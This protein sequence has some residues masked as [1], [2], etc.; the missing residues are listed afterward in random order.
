MEIFYI[1]LI[2]TIGYFLFLFFKR[3]GEKKQSEILLQLKA[4]W[5]NPKKDYFNFDVISIYFDQVK[6]DCFQEVG[7]KMMLDLDLESVFQEIDHTKSKIGQQYLYN[8]FRRPKGA[9]NELEKIDE[10]VEHF[11]Q[12][13][14]QVFDLQKF[15]SSLNDYED[16][17]FPFLIFGELPEKQVGFGSFTYCKD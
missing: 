12:H 11:S 3:K 4:D 7:N 6:E 17:Y 1:L 9:K 14:T 10:A 2:L 15:L 16:Y 13:P 8:A 5:G